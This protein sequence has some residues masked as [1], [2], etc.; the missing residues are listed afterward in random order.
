MLYALIHNGVAVRIFYT[1]WHSWYSALL[2]AGWHGIHIPARDF[3]VSQTIEIGS[4]AH[5]AHGYQGSFPELKQLGCVDYSPSS[6]A[7]V[8]NDWSCTSSPIYCHGMGKDNYT[9]FHLFAL[10]WF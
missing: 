2:Q 4:G 5:L 6:S 10:Y 3:C 1:L 7:E 8:K 9:F